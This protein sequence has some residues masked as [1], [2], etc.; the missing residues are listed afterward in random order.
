MRRSTKEKMIFCMLAL[1]WVLFLTGM[2]TS[3]QQA[4][5]LSNVE[6]STV[7]EQEVPC[8]IS[9]I[10]AEPEPI[11]EEPVVTRYSAIAESISQKE[12]GLMA[13]VVYHESRGEPHDGQRAVAEV[14][15]NRTLSDQFP[16]TIEKVIYQK[17]NG[18]YQFSCAPALTTAAIQEPG[19]LANCFDVVDEVLAETEYAVPAHYY[20]F[21]TGSTK[22]ADHIK[23]GH[24][25]FR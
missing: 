17:Y 12:K 23:I 9:E 6:L 19:A 2:V 3:R 22:K 20:F 5:N 4:A 7:E 10:V 15:L 24:H 25:T 11:I 16:G 8:A 13:M 18:K 21:S 1:G 14:I